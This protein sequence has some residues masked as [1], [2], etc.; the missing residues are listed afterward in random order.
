ME[1]CPNRREECDFLKCEMGFATCVDGECVCLW[2][3]NYIFVSFKE[4]V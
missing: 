4:Q 3:T 2:V 1:E